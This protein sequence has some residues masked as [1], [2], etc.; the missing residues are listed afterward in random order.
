MAEIKY[1]RGKFAPPQAYVDYI[2]MIA[3]SPVYKGLPAIRAEDG[4]INWQCSSGKTTSFYKYF[5]GRFQWWVKKADE[6][7]VEGT[8]NSDDRLTVAARRIHPTKKKV[9]LVCGKERYVGYMYMNAHYAKA[10]NKLLGK[11]RFEKGTP[12]YEATKILVDRCGKSKVRE[13]LLSDF[14]EKKDDIALFDKGDYEAFFSKTQHIRSTKLSPGYMGDCP[15]RLDGLHDYCTFCRKRSDP[16]RSDENM[17]TYNHDRRAFMWW[18]EGDWKV[19]DTLYN[20]AKS[21]TCVN[22]KKKVR[23]ISPDHIGPL[24]CGFKQNGFFKPLCGTCNSAKNRRFTFKDVMSLR[25]HEK[26]TG[27]SVASWQVSVLWD[28]VK[29]AVQDDHS[30]KILSNY[31]RAMQDYYLRALAYIATLGHYEFL[32]SYLHPEYAYYD[33]A[34]TGLDPGTLT[35][36][37]VKKT[38]AFSNGSRSIAARS[39]RIAFEEL[40]EYCAKTTAQRKS[41]ILHLVDDFLEEDKETIGSIFAGRQLTEM[42]KKLG[43]LIGSEEYSLEDKDRAIQKLIEAPAFAK[44]VARSKEYDKKFRKLIDKRGRSLAKRCLSEIK[45]KFG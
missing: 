11:K 38:V 18:A 33:V 17:R 29:E 16:G 26:E 32:S 23:K 6:L 36:K 5:P 35:F 40:F 19:A 2:N 43:A 10:W 44:R 3:D 9:C 39:V 14:P 7:G 31:M 1:G 15:H 22:C 41:A 24:S 27:E 20:S 12:I 4:K 28:A 30:V 42:D 8:E 34:F 37:K 45:P 13:I 21:G 25:G